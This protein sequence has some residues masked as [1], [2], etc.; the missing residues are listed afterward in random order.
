LFY[1]FRPLEHFYPASN[2]P[3]YKNVSK[4]ERE[5]IAEMRYNNY[6]ARVNCKQEF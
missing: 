5:V 1:L 2:D 4:Q 6:V 3:E